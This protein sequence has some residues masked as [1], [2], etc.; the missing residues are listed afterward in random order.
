MYIARFSYDIAPIN[1]QRAIELIRREVETARSNN[2]SA[3]LLIPLTRA[4]GAAALQFEVELLIWTNLIRFDIAVQ[5]QRSRPPV[6]CA[7]SAKCWSLRPQWKS[8]GSIDAGA[9]TELIGQPLGHERVLV[10]VAL[11]RSCECGDW[12]SR[13]SAQTCRAGDVHGWRFCPVGTCAGFLRAEGHAAIRRNRVIN[14]CL[15]RRHMSC[16]SERD[17]DMACAR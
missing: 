8:C 16:L 6:G 1:R 3:R 2:Q 5:G 17:K 12:S 4:H 14:R 15:P 13:Q 11:H 10:S 7:S 9:G